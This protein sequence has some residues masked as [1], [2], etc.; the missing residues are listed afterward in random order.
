MFIDVF[1]D[2]SDSE[3]FA[4]SVDRYGQTFL[5]SARRQIEFSRGI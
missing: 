2:N 3:E 4:F 1:G 5:R